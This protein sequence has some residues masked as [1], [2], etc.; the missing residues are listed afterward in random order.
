MR[1]AIGARARPLRLT[2]QQFWAIVVLQREQGTSPGELGAR[3]LLDAPA[4]SR[5]IAALTQRKLV[6]VRPDREDRRRTHLHLSPAGALLAEKVRAVA[7]E[8]QAAM[9]RGLGDA[10]QDAVRAALGRIAENLA[11]LEGEGASAD[12]RSAAVR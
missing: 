7:E 1:A 3:L 6:E 2:P 4:A 10:E 12:R 11:G 9:V 8:F 5:V